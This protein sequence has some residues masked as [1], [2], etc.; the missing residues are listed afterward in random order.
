MKYYS[1]ET[2]MLVAG[3][4]GYTT[5][6]AVADALVPIFGQ[7]SKVMQNKIK[8]GRFTKE[9]C[10]VIGSFFEM[11]LKE[12]YDVFMHGLFVEDEFGRYVCY[13]DEPYLHLHPAKDGRNPKDYV[14]R[15]REHLLKEIENME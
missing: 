10:E 4:R 3:D 8:S 6:R 9:E 12:Y 5:I 1:K 7:T 13:V 2:L 15:K 11:T 14:R